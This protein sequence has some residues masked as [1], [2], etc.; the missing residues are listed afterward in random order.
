MRVFCQPEH[1][2]VMF[3]D[4]L[5]WV[6]SATLKLLELVMTDQDSTALFLIGAYRDNEVDPTHP[7]KMTLDKIRF[8]HVTINQITLKPLAFE[9]LNQLIADSLHHNLE[10]VGALTELV[11]RK[12]GGNP[13]FVNQ[14]LQTLYEENLLTFTP[15][16]QLSSQDASLITDN[17]LLKTE[18]W[19]WDIDQIEALNITDNVVELMISKLKKL[20]KTAQQVLR[21]A[22][23][24][25]NRFDLDTL[26]VIYEKSTT[27]TF[28][29]LRPV[30]TEGLILPLSELEITGSD[31]KHSSFI[32]HN[33]QFLHDR[34]QQAAYAGDDEQKKAVH[35]QIG[36]L[37]H[38]NTPK[39]ALAEH[40]F[41]IVD[42]LNQG[43]ELIQNQAERNEIAGLN[44]MAG[45]KAKAATAYE[46][47]FGY[48][49]IG[50]ECLAEMSWEMN[51]ELTLSLHETALETAFMCGELEKMEKL[52][53]AVLAH[54]KGLLDM[55][56]T[57]DIR[58]NAYTI[59]AKYQQAIETGLEFLKL[60][61]KKLPANPTPLEIQSTLVN[62][63]TLLKQHSFEELLRLPEMTDV[64]R[65]AELKIVSRLIP[66]TFFAN[67]NLLPLLTGRAIELSVKYG[68]NP[69]TPF[70]YGIYGL[71]ASGVAISDFENAYHTSQLALK[72]L[73]KQANHPQKSPVFN[74]VYGFVNH[75]KE[76]LKNSFSP[77]KAGYHAAIETGNLEFAGYT[78]SNYLRNLYASGTQLKQVKEECHIYTQSMKK[79]RQIPSLDCTLSLYQAI[80]NLSE[81]TEPSILL[82]GEAFHEQEIHRFIKELSVAPL[83]I[84]YF[85]KLNL[86]LLFGEYEKGL[87]YGDE[88]H[89]YVIHIGG[90]NPIPH[91]YF[92]DTLLRLIQAGSA[93]KTDKTD[94]RIDEGYE[95]IKTWTEQAPM[96]YRHMQSLVE[97]EQAHLSDQVD[98]AMKLYEK[99]ISDARENGF[100]QDE[101]LSYEL[102]AKFYLEQ[103]IEPVAQLY[104]KEAHYRYQQWGTLAKL[105]DLE[106]RYPQFLA[107][108][109]AS[110]MPTNAT[111]SATRMAYISTKG[112][113]E[114]LD[115]N[116]IM[117]AAQTLSGEIVLSRLL[118]KMMLIVIENA[119]AEKGFL[120]LQKND[121]WFIEAEGQVDNDEVHV[122]QSI[123]FEKQ[124]STNII[125]YVIH[126]QENV[127][128]NDAT[129]EGNFIHDPYVVKQHPQSV[130]CMPL[131]NQGL[132]IGIL[133]LENNLTTGAFTPERLEV[134]NLLSS[135]I[136]IS[137]ENSLLYNN[138]EQ[139]VTERTSELRESQRAMRTL[140]SNLPGIAYRCRND[141]SRT[142]EFMSD[143]CLALTGYPPTAFIDN[144]E[145]SFTNVIHV[146]DRE[147]LWQ[148]VQDAL[149]NKQP[150]EVTYR[151]TTN[152]AQLKW[153]WEQ[154]EG[155]FDQHGKLVAIEGLIN[156]ISEQKQTEIALQQAKES[157]EIANQAKSSF[158]A[159]MS[160]ELRTPLNGILGF[161]QILQRDSSIT[162]K[163]QHGLNVIEQSGHH[164]LS[165]INDVLDMAKVEAGKIELHKVDFNLPS[166]LNGVSEVIKIRAE[167]KGIQFSLE[168]AEELP[169]CVHGDERR[170]RQILL[171]L[172]GNAIKFTEHGSVT[173]KVCVNADSPA[174]SPNLPQT[175]SPSSLH[176]EIEDTGVG[177]SPEHLERI[178][179]PFEQ[180]GEQ[181]RQAKGTGLGLAISKNLVELMGGQ[182]YV[183]SQINIGTQ[184]WFALTLP[185]ID[186]NVTKVSTQQPI[187]G[188]K[189]KSPKILV[190]DDNEENQAVVVDLLSQLGFNVE[191]ANDGHEGLEKAI[192][193]QPDAIITDLIMPKMDGFELIHQ[194]RQSPVLKYKVII[195]SS[196][197]VYETD[198]KKSLAIG[199]H[200]FLPKPIQVETLLE[201]LQQYLNI[202]YIYGDKVKETLEENHTAQI[203]FPPVAEL[204]KLYELALMADIDELEEQVAVLAKSEAKLKP[205]VT[206]M[207]AFLKKYQVGKLTEWLERAITNGK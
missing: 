203:V 29:D 185:V 104:L 186:Y 109:T 200:A 113:S 152:T 164:L 170:L 83:V 140:I 44:L 157:A 155:V 14:F 47:A 130:L 119:G 35:L 90:L 56:L 84:Y 142:M 31:I 43:V 153:F 61:N 163:Q 108:K 40:L 156:D 114:W 58:I 9:H 145:I 207:Q 11:M 70:A 136:A 122:L 59:E 57:Y 12:T 173:L 73:E 202:T 198:K 205:F 3:L 188:I 180:V 110:A 88:G 148:I 132:L 6:D 138:L 206:K 54:A 55:T 15:P 7:L 115:L 179:E 27:E 32:I 182:L 10:T 204:E 116:S 71:M 94:N 151:I 41:E 169:N 174:C 175:C 102:A 166:L 195:A 190:V 125:N 167:H 96:N 183:S 162:T 45:Q 62:I 160:H 133:Y 85:S 159:G 38:K 75:W 67:P 51:Y 134:L 25:G 80:L 187:I 18:G 121:T 99:A 178:F 66:A 128:L 81:K 46:A 118:E 92:Y 69:M 4:D 111:I 184:F 39:Q 42:Q 19:Q 1:P 120:L 50:L 129:Q 79:M 103:G 74:S 161:V 105:K 24:I 176:F 77:L 76:P 154:G 37:L 201:Q 197:S 5:Q 158:L 192:S 34:V 16:T 101:A 17:C 98:K 91:F 172:L 143:G 189:G 149:Q 199:S 52:A 65:L 2:L 112:N 139:K 60:L 194:L 97:A 107:P 63:V 26:S 191:S 146:D 137:I 165:L 95:R 106:T 49:G 181:E 48:L 30:L 131:I 135:Q 100:L 127:V 72:L 36:R 147:E 87:E 22:A 28:Q 171:N 86:C 144:A 53:D 124:L 168:S 150:F 13:F 93:E 141:R 20:P 21:L 64:Y 193:W 177:I 126:T 196:A 8:D 68:N 89:K 123:A 23:C 82:E 117:K 78:S 33:S